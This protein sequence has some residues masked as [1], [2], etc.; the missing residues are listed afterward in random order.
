ML[1]I[2]KPV[3]VPVNARAQPDGLA[4][5]MSDWITAD[6]RA[7][8]VGEGKEYKGVRWQAILKPAP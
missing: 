4:D 5:T 1:E 8:D 7:R 6:K 3:T 2:A